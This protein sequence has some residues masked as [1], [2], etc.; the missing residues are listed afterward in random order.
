[1]S[2]RRPPAP[3]PRSGPLFWLLS[4]VL[5]IAVPGVGHIYAQMLT[6]G[7]IWLAGNLAVLLI[8]SQ[9]DVGTGPL[10]GAL[11]ALRA[12]AVVDLVLLLR[13]GRHDPDAGGGGKAR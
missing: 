4:V 1:M 2:A 9:G 8:L 12:A 13:S 7:F 10:L 11:G 5:T 6:R 3:A